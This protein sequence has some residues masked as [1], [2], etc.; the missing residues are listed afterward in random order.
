[1][2]M[3]IKCRGCSDLSISGLCKSDIF[4]KAMD[5]CPCHGCPVKVMCDDPCDTF[6]KYADENSRFNK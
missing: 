2:E 1:M 5:I 4:P 3:N 6:V